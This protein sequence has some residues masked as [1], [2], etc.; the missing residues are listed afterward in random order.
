MNG[1]L[2]KVSLNIKKCTYISGR[3]LHQCKKAHCGIFRPLWSSYNAI[4]S[5]FI[6]VKVTKGENWRGGHNR[7]EG[8]K[9]KDK[10]GDKDSLHSCLNTQS[11]PAVAWPELPRLSYL[12]QNMPVC[13]LFWHPWI[14]PKSSGVR[15]SKIYQ[16]HIWE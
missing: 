12:K 7:F 1:K 4:K 9:N 3:A 16:W 13:Q 6:I 14:S 5:K 2:F 15:R 11:V 10:Q 8:K